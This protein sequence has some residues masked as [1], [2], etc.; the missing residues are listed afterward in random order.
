M[1]TVLTGIDMILRHPLFLVLA[2]GLVSSYLIPRLS[3]RWQDHQEAI[4]TRTRFA[5]EITETVVRFLLS[6][7]LSERR[8]IKPEQYDAAYQEWEVRRATLGSEL[9]GRFEDASVAADW[10]ALSEAVTALYRLSG[11]SKEPYRSMVL[12]EL[13]AYFSDEATDWERL[14]DLEQAWG[15]NDDFQGYFAAWWKLREATL[16]ESGELARKILE[17]K[18]TSFG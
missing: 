18:T 8:A 10:H 6:V 15:S 2:T 3:R 7:Q 14:R 1:D 17:S 4:E 16:R 9:R 13:K 12:G 11:T 5:S